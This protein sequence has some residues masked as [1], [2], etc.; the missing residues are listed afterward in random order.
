[1]WFAPLTALALV[2]CGK[3][4]TIDKP[5]AQVS[6]MLSSLPGDADAMSLA[7][8]MPGTSYWVEPTANKVIWHFVR[9]SGEYGRYVVELSESGSEKTRVTTHFE[10]GPADRGLKFL[11]E[12]ATIAGDASV[13]AAVEGRAV[14][15]SAVQA[16]ISQRIASDPMASMATTMESV[17][18]EMDRM[19]PPD[20]CKTGTPKQMNSWVCEKHGHT[21]NGDT[22]VITESDTGRVVNSTDE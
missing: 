10:D 1:L 6:M 18:D 22:G 12:I 21:I 17:A 8:T 15:R 2:G 16:K 14:D 11:D 7:T 20:T 9:Q 4:Q 5:M 19:A 13:A 3:S